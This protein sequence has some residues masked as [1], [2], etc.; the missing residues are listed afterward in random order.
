MKE[1]EPTG[2]GARPWRP[3]LG[4]ANERDSASRSVD[5]EFNLMLT[6]S[7]DKD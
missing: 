1:F 6:L 2:G 4:S 3:P 7:S 5:G